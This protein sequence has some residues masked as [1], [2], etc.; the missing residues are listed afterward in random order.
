MI[1][2][3]VLDDDPNKIKK[4][5]EAI[6][7]YTEIKS[8]NITTV[9]DITQAKKMLKDNDYDILLLDIQIP[10]KFGEETL[11]DGGVR[12]LKELV[13]T[14]RY[15][16]PAH[17][18][19]ITA[20]DEIYKEFSREFSEQ[21]WVVVNCGEGAVNWTLQIANKVRYVLDLKK[22][23]RV[24]IR[25]EYEYDLAIV[26]AL[27][28]VEFENV[29]KLSNDWAK[30]EITNDGEN[31]YTCN[32]GNKK[33]VAATAPEMGMTSSAVLATK[34]VINFCPKYLV[35][36]GIAAGIKNKVNLGDVLIADPS[37]DYGSGKIDETNGKITFLPDPKQIRISADI[38]A[39]FENIGRDRE[40]LKKLRDNW[41]AEKPE[42]EISLHIG[43]VGTGAFVVAE[44]HIQEIIRE[45]NR[46]II[47]FDM[48]TYGVLYAAENSLKPRPIAFSIKSVCDFGDSEKNDK[49]QRYAAYISTNILKEFISKH[50]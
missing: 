12:L 34:M 29:L 1:K 50:I 4:I 40:F 35:M 10:N 22:G 44:H 13:E 38:R 9:P 41:P 20:Y 5:T 14:G 21:L 46:N 15:R 16:R 18:I 45:H 17:I 24:P 47:G 8:E 25:T 30:Y 43:P 26:T 23:L 42:N 28:K 27:D 11:R 48:E 6:Y 31:Y 2:I 39:I 32:I 36:V 37:W 33:V 19:G 49:Y 3:L 7:K